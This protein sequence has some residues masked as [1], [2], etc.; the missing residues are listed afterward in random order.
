MAGLVGVDRGEKRKSNGEV[1]EVGW[2]DWSERVDYKVEI[3]ISD[4]EEEVEEKG[5]E[6]I[7]TSVAIA[8]QA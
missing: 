7:E 8:V 6:V 1:E 2:R 4:T 5:E 3:E